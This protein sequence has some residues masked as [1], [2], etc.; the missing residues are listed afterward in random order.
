MSSKQKQRLNVIVTGGSCGI[1]RSIVTRFAS[2]GHRVLGTFFSSRKAAEEI[3]E[4]FS[5]VD[6]CMLDQGDLESIEQFAQYCNAWLKIE[7]PSCNGTFH[8]FKQISVVCT[9]C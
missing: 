7:N 3:K 2:E 6:F 9:C 5:N 8:H 4:Q 1:G